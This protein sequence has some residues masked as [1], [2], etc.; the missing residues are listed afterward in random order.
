MVAHC[1]WRYA[2]P[3]V[4]LQLLLLFSRMRVRRALRGPHAPPLP[5][6][7]AAALAGLPLYPSDDLSPCCEVAAGTI[8]RALGTGFLSRAALS[9]ALAPAAARSDRAAA[10]A[11]LTMCR[12]LL[13]RVFGSRLLSEIL[14]LLGDGCGAGECVPVCVRSD[15]T[16]L[17]VAPSAASAYLR[18]RGGVSWWA[19]VRSCDVYAAAAHID[20][21]VDVNCAECGS[22][23]TVMHWAA[24]R[25]HVRM[26]ELA[27]CCGARV[28]AGDRGGCTALHIAARNDHVCAVTLL[29]NCG[30]DVDA[31]GDGHFTPLLMA[32]YRGHFSVARALLAL[33]ADLSAQCD[34]R[35]TALHWA[36][37]E[38]QCDAVRLLLS[39]AA[40]VNAAAGDGAT[41]LHLAAFKGQCAAMLLLLEVGA[42]VNARQSTGPHSRD[43]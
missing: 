26:M 34:Q 17:Q 31:R 32:A 20:L 27:V 3:V 23:W 9:L 35:R 37:H 2:C 8:T 24:A 13:S 21:G 41:P 40:D 19:A 14:T 7:P 6:A 16:A 39:C 18:A 1:E 11:S 42:D 22:D 12:R 29:V 33:K 25:G 30:A 38:G 4:Y 5:C 36:A 15:T 28:D 43:R 10:K